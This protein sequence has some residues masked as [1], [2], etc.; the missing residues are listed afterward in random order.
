MTLGIREAREKLPSLIKRA[1][2]AEEDIRFGTRG[3]EEVTL[4]STDKY[5]RLQEELRRLRTE[6]A[7]LRRRVSAATNSGEISPEPFA[8]LQRALD[9]GELSVAPEPRVRRVIANDSG[10]SRVSREERIRLGSRGDHEPER[11]RTGPRA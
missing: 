2:F 3:N 11:R 10:V 8:G 4:V 7:D 1:A 6:V 5:A 9:A